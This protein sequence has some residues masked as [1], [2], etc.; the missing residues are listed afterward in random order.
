[1]AR[2]NTLF[3]ASGF[4]A[5]A[6][7]LFFL[8]L[9][10]YMLF[11]SSKNHIFAL[12][13]DDFISISIDLTNSDVQN[14]SASVD[15]TIEAPTVQEEQTQEPETQ[16]QDID[17]G[18]LFNNVWTKEIKKEKIQEKKP[19]DTKRFQE[20]QKRIK[21]TKTQEV[22]SLSKK[23]ESITSEE[24]SDAKKSSST[25]NEVNEYRAKIQAIVYKHFHPPQN[26][27]GNSVR[28]V[29]ELSALGKMLDFRIL[30]YSSNQLLNEES[31]RV[32]A[33]LRGVVFPVNPENKSGNYIIILRSEE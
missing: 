24:G 17:V 8:S 30:N 16:A 12:K 26:S 28:A 25:G 22:D 27:Q 19:V 9:F 18:D 31:D 3:Y 23:I 33:R 2:D 29:I 14:K 1:M 10:A 21:K 7:F 20:I 13:K 32:K 5:L 6:L 11:T 4:L 15:K